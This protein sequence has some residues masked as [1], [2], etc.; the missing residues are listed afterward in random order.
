MTDKIVPLTSITV[1]AKCD[2]GHETP[3][4]VD[5]CF[6]S[7]DYGEVLSIRWDCPVCPNGENA[8]QAF[9]S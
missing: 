3:M 6:N 5:K 7:E 8:Y 9:L 1:V 4:F 2:N